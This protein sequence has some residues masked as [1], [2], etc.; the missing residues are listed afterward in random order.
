LYED[1]VVLA[2]KSQKGYRGHYLFTDRKTGK[3]CSISLW[4]SEEDA[5]TNE[6]SGY[7]KEQVGKFAEYFT[8]PP[9]QEGYEVSVQA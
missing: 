6:Q 1:S 5:I 3:G 4:N 9:V 7:Y 8:A 2:A